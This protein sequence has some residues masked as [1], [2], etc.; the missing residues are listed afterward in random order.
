MDLGEEVE[1]L[2]VEAVV[3]EVVRLWLGGGGPGQRDSSG[4]HG[5]RSLLPHRDTR[6]LCVHCAVQS[7]P[8]SSRSD[9]QFG[10]KETE[11]GEGR[12]KEPR[13]LPSSKTT[14]TLSVSGIW[15]RRPWKLRS[16]CT[17][18]GRAH[19]NRFI[20]PSFLGKIC[21]RSCEV[22]HLY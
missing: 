5:R 18:L 3:V 1:E 12:N 11:P 14:R 16:R 21:Y 8:A 20:D 4:T 13:E 22:T 19:S 9:L 7:Q 15:K 6:I 17:F 10:G 2:R